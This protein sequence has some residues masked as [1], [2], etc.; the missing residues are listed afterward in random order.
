MKIV[1][2][3][4]VEKFRDLQPINEDTDAT[5]LKKVIYNAQETKIQ[6]HLGTSLYKKILTLVDTG[7]ISQ[8]GNSKY[9]ELLDDYITK[10]LSYWAYVDAIPH[11]TYQFTDK[12]VSQRDGNHSRTAEP[13]AVKAKVMRAEN[14]AEFQTNLMLTF[15][16]NKA[17]DYP[18][19]GR[20]D[21]GIGANNKP[22]F[23]GMEL[24]H[25][26]NEIDYLNRP[27]HS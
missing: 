27:S 9:K 13:A 17:S 24:D 15:L 22:F 8:P 14:Q 2:L 26:D 11:M 1:R 7:D 20:I 23:S 16:C 10:V 18:E 19:H 25:Y 4:P 21:D 6:E 12:G 3:L 5:I